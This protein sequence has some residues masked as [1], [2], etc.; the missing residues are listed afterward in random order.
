M[1]VLAALAVFAAVLVGRIGG[2]RHPAYVVPAEPV[3]SAAFA[4]AMEAYTSAS[5]VGGNRVDVLLNGDEIFPAM[6]AAIRSARHSITYAQ[7]FFQDGPVAHAVIDALAERCRAGIPV[8]V[9]LDGVG[10]MRMPRAFTKNLEAASCHVKTFRPLGRLSIVRANHRNHRRIL[11]VD[12]R[13]G[14]T[15]GSGVSWKWMGDGRRPDHWRDTDARVEGPAVEFLQAAFVGS[16]LAVTGEMLGGETYFVSAPSRA[17]AVHAQI[18]K[19]SPEEGGDAM[20]R[21]FLLAA[22]A[23]RRSIL[24]TNPYFLPDDALSELLM[25]AVKRGVSVQV[26][27]PGVVDHELV[28]QASRAEFGQM[29]QAGIEIY[30]YQAALLHAKTM[31]VDGLWAT[32]GSTNLDNRSFAL[33]EELNLVVYDA[34]VA[35]RLEAAFRD[36]LTRAARVTYET[37]QRRPFKDRILEMITVPIRSLM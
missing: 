7:Y 4:N 20:Y 34:A 3:G 6:L 8:H 21:L 2:P 15:G 14:F 32:V 24:L 25:Q 9:L 28:R 13:V 12:G 16:W 22:R 23:A 36:D 33:N 27:V 37:W 35:G 1:I 17:G 26:L 19:S 30:E 18:V 11:V 10:T 5:I 31:V 29:L